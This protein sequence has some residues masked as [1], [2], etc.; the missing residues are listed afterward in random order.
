M[1]VALKQ[2]WVRNPVAVPDLPK[3]KP[4][5]SYPEYQKARRARLQAA[6]YTVRGTLRKRKI[7]ARRK[8]K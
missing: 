7:Y 4:Q 3:R 1:R 6:G 5:F 2:G 8:T